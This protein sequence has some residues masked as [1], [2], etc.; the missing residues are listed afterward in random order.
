MSFSDESDNETT[1]LLGPSTDESVLSK[2]SS[3]FQGFCPVVK[4]SSELK[5]EDDEVLQVEEFQTKRV[6][7]NSDGIQGRR[8]PT[9]EQ[10]LNNEMIPKTV[11]IVDSS[12]EELNIQQSNEMQTPPTRLHVVL[13]SL[14]YIYLLTTISYFHF[15]F[16]LFDTVI[17][18]TIKTLREFLDPYAST[19]IITQLIVIPFFLVIIDHTCYKPFMA[20]CYPFNKN[21]RI[22]HDD[23]DNGNG[24]D[25]NDNGNDDQSSVIHKEDLVFDSNDRGPLDK[26][27]DGINQSLD[28][29]TRNLPDVST[30]KYRPLFIQAAGDTNCPGHNPNES[31]P[32]GVPFS[33][34]SNLFKGK[35]LLRA[36]NLKAD[37]TE[38]TK[39]YFKATKQCI[40]RQVVIQG[41][42]KERMK[43]SDVWMGDLYEKK[44]NL[45]PPPRIAKFMSKIFNRLAPGIVLD[46]ATS[47]PK[48]LALMGSACHTI[49][50]DKPG[51]EPD[52]M[53][54]E[55][56]ENTTFG[57]DLKSSDERKR[58]W[59][60]PRTA[61]E[62]E[63][64]PDL[65][66]TFHSMDEVLDFAEYKVLLPI[67][68]MDITKILGDGQPM[69]LRGVHS[70]NSKSFFYFR[71]W[72]ERTLQRAAKRN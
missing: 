23:D 32:I 31:L 56:P 38:S 36:K 12:E 72:H 37:D 8:K 48:V 2:F 7:K 63:F 18:P 17:H 6:E 1:I 47:H 19:I 30:W 28:E 4:V 40:Q 29:A 14:I 46:L 41:Q 20:C 5:S 43:M 60:L 39:A 15:G 42:F 71:V 67:L 26:T 21:T 27:S 55:L 62:H 64:D 69:S 13:L 68:K 35:I 52:M 58:I 53:L 50:V 25:D 49:S 3:I 22:H 61:S 16:D 45:S 44:L 57:N 34:E 54:P 33:F 11:M 70:D 59:G 24:D 9:K 10:N 51:Q 66:Y 65:V